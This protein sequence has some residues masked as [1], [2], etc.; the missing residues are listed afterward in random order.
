MNGRISVRER[1]AAL[2]ALEAL[3]WQLNQAGAWLGE[4]GAETETDMLEQAARSILAACWLLSRPIRGE[5]GPERWQVAVSGTTVD[6]QPY[7]V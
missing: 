4:C 3:A 5:P 2:D 6:G 1:V 7:R